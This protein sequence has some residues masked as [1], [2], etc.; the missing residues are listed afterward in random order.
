MKVIVKL[1]DKNE[2]VIHER[3]VTENESIVS[4]CEEMLDN[5]IENDN[6]TILIGYREY[7]NLLSKTSR[8]DKIMKARNNELALSILDIYRK[9]E[10]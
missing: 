7:F 8:Y 5:I 2:V 10:K 1:I 6:D 3:V 4:V 9:E